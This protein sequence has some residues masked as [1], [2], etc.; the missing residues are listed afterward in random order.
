MSAPYQ[1]GDTV[2]LSTTFTVSGTL[3]DPSA[4]TLTVQA[5]DGTATSYVYLTDAEVVKDATGTFHADIVFATAG[6]WTW[7][8]LGTG[9]AA[10]V[11]EGTLTVERTLLGQGLLCS[12][13]D[14]RSYLQKPSGDTAQNDMIEALIARAS[15]SIM[16][17][18]EREFAPAGAAGVAR[19]F[20]WTGR[21][22]ID[23]VPYDVRAVTA[24]LLDPNLDAA[25]Q[26]TLGASDYM[27][28]PV[29][30]TDGVYQ[31][32]AVANTASQGS[33]TTR[34]AFGWRQV[35]VTGTWGFASVP[36]D[37]S[38]ACLM[39]VAIWMRR[40]VQAFSTTFN[41]DEARLERPEALPS[42][43]KGMLMPWCRWGP[44]A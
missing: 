3:T 27:L 26:T 11:D 12:V 14:V 20:A 5:P 34:S 42:A 16:R 43:V 21:G 6:I 33:S 39:A 7:K 44:V 13:D 32:I 18:C 9:T 40:D 37:V 19:T 38:Y 17:F 24:V 15:R 8:W 4:V 2:R 25:D 23:L 30:A 31:S 28:M 1:P 29:E 41:T 10:G 22:H 35:Q 36:A